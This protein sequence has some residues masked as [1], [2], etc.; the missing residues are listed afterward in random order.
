M[1]KIIR[2]LAVSCGIASIIAGI[3]IG[4]QE[5]L[6]SDMPIKISLPFGTFDER[7]GIY[8]PLAVAS[9]FKEISKQYPAHLEYC[10]NGN[11]GI[12][13]VIGLG[14][15][16][17]VAYYYTKKGKLLGFFDPRGPLTIAPV[18]I[19]GYHCITEESSGDYA[20]Y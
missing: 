6:K 20:K 4:P 3:E 12:F 14:E 8:A 1:T 16:I 2:G 18:S 7:E 19:Q 9:K 5:Q 13:R 17:S 15:R 11:Q 10:N